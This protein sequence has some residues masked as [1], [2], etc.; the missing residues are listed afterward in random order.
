MG[1][2]ELFELHA[3]SA[4]CRQGRLAAEDVRSSSA[5][6]LWPALVSTVLVCL[7]LLQGLAAS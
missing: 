7:G 4:R 2:F 6:L 3:G 5:Q 1:A